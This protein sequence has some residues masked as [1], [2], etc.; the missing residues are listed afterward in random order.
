MKTTIKQI[1]TGAFIAILL[2]VG[3]VKATELKALSGESI[4]IETTLQ[5]ENW[6]V[7]DLVWNSNSLNIAILVQEAEPSMELE[8]WMTSTE[9][10][11]LNNGFVEETE[12]V[13]EL[14]GWMTNDATWYTFKNDND[15]EPTLTVENWMVNDSIWE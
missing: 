6:M 1:T 2:M 14:E 10:W 13:L 8:N 3:N 12:M 11:N 5:M 15:N 7:N 4:E 9:S